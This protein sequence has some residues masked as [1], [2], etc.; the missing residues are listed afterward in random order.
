VP[1]G[2]S[3][4]EVSKEISE[5]AKHAARHEA[6]DQTGRH[7]LISIAEAVLLSIVTLTAAWSGYSAAKW[8]GHARIELAEASS[9]RTQASTAAATAI[10][11]RTQDTVNFG[12]W[13]NA[14]LTGN[15][16]G[17]A[18]AEH[19]FRPAYDVAF[20]AWLA[21][22]PFAN[23]RAPRSPAYMPQYTLPGQASARR[24]T[25]AADAHFAEGQ[26]S[27]KN[28]EDYIRVTVILASVLFIVG[29]SS[30]FRTAG[31]RVGLVAVGAV[32]LILGTIAILQLPGP[33]S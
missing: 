19:R 9:A 24:H 23:Q 31:I 21:T 1:E 8:E 12:I 18:L 17:Q 29:I 11:V 22:D 32:L 13:F 33:P 16:A 15:V 4:T 14:Y 10:T 28:A 6:H 27:G 25:A 7:E 26:M 20:R 2:L 5:H 3:A 30:H